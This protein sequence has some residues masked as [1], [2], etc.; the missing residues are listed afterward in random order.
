VNSNKDPSFVGWIRLYNL[1]FIV[2]LAIS[3]FVFLVLNF[4]SPPPGLGEEAPFVN[5]EVLYGVGE[6]S[7]D[8]GNEGLGK[9]SD[10]LGV[11]AAVSA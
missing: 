2:G 11:V 10:K 8:N 5:G 6:E 7:S 4:I 9:D 1:T 3:F